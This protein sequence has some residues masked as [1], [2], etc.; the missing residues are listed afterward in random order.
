MGERIADTHI[1]T[2]VEWGEFFV[3]T[4]ATFGQLNRVQ[5][6]VRV[7]PLIGN[8]HYQVLFDPRYDD[9]AIKAEITALVPD[10]D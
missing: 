7:E 10:T 8:G 2:D 3:W 9:V 1:S 4:D 6:I 5:G